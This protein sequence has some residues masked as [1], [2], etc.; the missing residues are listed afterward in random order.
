MADHAILVENLVKV[1]RRRGEPPVPAVDGLSFDVA[2]GS[3]FGLL[4][5]NG[6]GKTTTLKVLR[7]RAVP[8]GRRQPRDVCTLSRPVRR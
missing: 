6:A 2:R 5:P 8:V 3:I 4:G 1:F 7:R